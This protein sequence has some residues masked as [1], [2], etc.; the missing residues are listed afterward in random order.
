MHNNQV[1]IDLLIYLWR[2]ENGKLIA[3]Q[4]MIN[5]WGAV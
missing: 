2:V 3:E 5:Q 4:S 1:L